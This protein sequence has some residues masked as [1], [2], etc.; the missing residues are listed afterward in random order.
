MV[1]LARDMDMDYDDIDEVKYCRDEALRIERAGRQRHAVAQHTRN[2][3][4]A[5]AANVRHRMRA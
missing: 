4:D 5:R 1:Q 2:P 3:A